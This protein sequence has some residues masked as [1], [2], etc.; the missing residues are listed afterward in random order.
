[1]K[2]PTFSNWVWGLMSGP[3]EQAGGRSVGPL[4]VNILADEW[5]TI[6]AEAAIK[7]KGS[8]PH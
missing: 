2:G 3:V 6:D 8:P 4:N 5:E 7:S 1:M